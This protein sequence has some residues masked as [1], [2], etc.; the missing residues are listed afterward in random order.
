MNQ[1]L[2]SIKDWNPIIQGALGSALFALIIWFLRYLFLKVTSFSKSIS[3]KRERNEL[4]RYFINKY[5]VNSDGMFY[6]TQGYLLVIY[7][8]LRKLIIILIL[9]VSW[10][11]INEFISLNLVFD[12]IFGVSML[13]VLISAIEWFNPKL[14]KGDISNYDPSVVK[15]VRDRLLDERLKEREVKSTLKDKE[16]EVEKIKREIENLQNQL[17]G[18]KTPKNTQ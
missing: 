18:N 10:Y 4:I 2:E 12:L 8:V 7:T 17:L 9:A 16:D 3:N 14:S 6:F 15:I 5:Y 11:L 1:L 13:Y